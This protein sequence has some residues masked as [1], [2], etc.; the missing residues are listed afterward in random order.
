MSLFCRLKL[1]IFK[2]AKALLDEFASRVV[3]VA[4]S[5]CIHLHVVSGEIMVLNVYGN[6]LGNPGPYGFGD[7]IRQPNG[8]WLTGFVGNVGVSTIFDV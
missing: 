2:F 6:I 7:V 3:V 1:H 5:R 8:S 4:N